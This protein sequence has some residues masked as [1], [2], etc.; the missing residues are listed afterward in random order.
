MSFSPPLLLGN[1][2]QFQSVAQLEWFA[3]R[4]IAG[5]RLTIVGSQLNLFVEFEMTV[6]VAGQNIGTIIAMPVHQQ[7]D[8]YGLQLLQVTLNPHHVPPEMLKPPS[9]ASTPLKPV[10]T[11]DTIAPIGGENASTE[12]CAEP[13]KPSGTTERKQSQL[14]V[15]KTDATP[16]HSQPSNHSQNSGRSTIDEGDY[17]GEFGGLLLDRYQDDAERFEVQAPW[18]DAP[19]SEAPVPVETSTEQAKASSVSSVAEA[20]SSDGTFRRA[21]M[22]T[23][24]DESL[25]IGMLI[26]TQTRCEVGELTLQSSDSLW[27]LYTDRLGRLCF[28]DDTLVRIERQIPRKRASGKAQKKAQVARIREA[29]VHLLSVL[30]DQEF[31]HYRFIPRGSSKAA[32]HQ[33]PFTVYVCDVML[34]LLKQHRLEEFK[35]HY[36]SR[37][38]HY[39]EAASEIP[40]KATDYALE[41]RATRFF[42]IVMEEEHSL[43]MLFKV[44][45]VSQGETYRLVRLG[46]LLNLLSFSREK[47]TEVDLSAEH[48]EYL[49]QQ[50]SRAQEGYFEAL[51][52]HMVTHPRKYERALDDIKETFSKSSEYA[53]HTYRHRELCAQIV[54]L[55][56]E[57]FRYLSDKSRRITY[58][59]ENFDRTV[60]RQSA[61]VLLEKADMNRLRGH[62]R[63]MRQALEMA[64]ELDP[65]LTRH[66]IQRH[67]DFEDFDP[68]TSD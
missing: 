2:L 28:D 6:T 20:R 59:N 9:V 43:R 36:Q 11:E 38:D 39:V 16:T 21:T 5:Q 12:D 14:V 63:R 57:A 13:V 27:T 30:S 22:L 56:E 19:Q 7:S 37:I 66:H 62:D 40:I 8:V 49:Q 67:S 58:R 18:T 68:S 23:S 29:L 4:E 47:L 53:L 65:Q 45:P 42:E 33:V 35:N 24:L 64:F 61:D 17:D 26:R 32:V 10:D 55:A 44:S 48:L 46:E 60:L 50:F 34:N 51:N 31:L 3:R 54:R 15:D 25:L 41:R 1:T 52:I